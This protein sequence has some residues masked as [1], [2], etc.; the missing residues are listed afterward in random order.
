[1]SDRPKVRYGTCE[2]GPFNRRHM[3][4]M[5]RAYLLAY[6]RHNPMK[7]FPGV[8]S[9]IGADI[10]FGAYVFDDATE[11]WKWFDE[12]AAKAIRSELLTAVDKL[13]W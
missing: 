10:L 9:S 5:P 1:M 2:G 11:I 12:P 13:P 6:E 8:Q 3:A 4:H 7:C